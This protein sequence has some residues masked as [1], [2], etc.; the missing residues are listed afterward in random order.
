MAKDSRLRRLGEG[1]VAYGDWGI[2][3]CGDWGKGK[4]TSSPAAIA[5]T[6]LTVA[7]RSAFIRFCSFR[8]HFADGTKALLTEEPFSITLFTSWHILRIK[9]KQLR[10]RV[11]TVA[12]LVCVNFCN[13]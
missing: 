11:T 8:L 1:K 4:S 2:V 12:I 3:A 7:S 10:K 13:F 6:T 5:A 9:G